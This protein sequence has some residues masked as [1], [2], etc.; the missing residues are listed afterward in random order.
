MLEGMEGMLDSREGMQ[1]RE[2][3]QGGERV[4]GRGAG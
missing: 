3:V 2:G 4:P 1:G